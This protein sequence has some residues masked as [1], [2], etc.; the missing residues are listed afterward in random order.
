[1]FTQKISFFYALIIGCTLHNHIT[2]MENVAQSI[3]KNLMI[4]DQKIVDL[5]WHVDFAKMVKIKD[6]KKFE[7]YQKNYRG[8]IG[9]PQFFVREYDH[10]HP[11]V[12]AYK[13]TL[14]FFT[15]ADK[16]LPLYRP[17]G[18]EAKHYVLQRTLTKYELAFTVFQANFE[19]AIRTNSYHYLKKVEE[20]IQDYLN[21]LENHT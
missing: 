13:G 14:L 20:D 2:A 21:K 12:R 17:D 11:A 10:T 5:S 3:E 4:L 19:R 7:R 9:D 6:Q 18:S 15:D 8:S 1:M 16:R